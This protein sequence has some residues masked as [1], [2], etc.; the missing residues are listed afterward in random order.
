MPDM[1]KITTP[2]LP[3]NYVNSVKPNQQP[4]QDVF[5]LVD[6]TRVTKPNER[7]E[8]PDNNALNLATQQEAKHAL[9]A[10]LKDPGLA[11][12]SLKRLLLMSAMLVTL[13]GEKYAGQAEINGLIKSLMLTEQDLL[14]EIFSQQQGISSFQGEF[15]DALRSLLS[16]TSNTEFKDSIGALLKAITGRVYAGDILDSIGINLEKYAELMRSV[17][18]AYDAL[19][20]LST[21]FKALSGLGTE[22]DTKMFTELKDALINVLRELNSSIY[23]SDKT[24]NLTALIVY[25]LS[26][27]VNDKDEINAAF[28]NFSRFLPEESR[29]SYRKALEDY[30]AAAVKQS[31]SAAL[32]SKVIGKLSEI[33]SQH[34]DG[35]MNTPAAMQEINN[36]LQSLA[37]APTAFTPLLHYILPLEDGNSSALAELWVDPDASR[38]NTSGSQNNAVKI[39]FVSDVEGVGHFE[40]EM[41]VA[42]YHID[43]YMFCPADYTDFFKGYKERISQLCKNTAYTFSNI[44]IEPLV[45][46]RRLDEVFTKLSV[47]RSGIDARA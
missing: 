11:I 20:D 8:T 28:E 37:T 21:N 10:L 31:D 17:P 3:K 33:I 26:K 34:L 15:F 12:S 39:F 18:E 42:D 45:K 47:R 23:A 7:G 27:F 38:E 46:E 25:N 13:N 14:T 5:N 40:L 22:P 44:S 30:L 2:I 41:L 43:L 16:G 36:I 29:A 19:H 4:S 32:Q 6:L 9:G 1:L 35:R 24:M